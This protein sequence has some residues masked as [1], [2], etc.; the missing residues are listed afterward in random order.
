MC[1]KS[2]QLE[3]MQK[4][5]ITKKKKNAR[6]LSFFMEFYG[7]ELVNSTSSHPI[8][9]SEVMEA[10]PFEVDPNCIHRYDKSAKMETARIIE[11]FL[12]AHSKE[13]LG[14]RQVYPKVIQRSAKLNM[15]LVKWK[16]Y[17]RGDGNEELLWN[18]DKAKTQKTKISVLSSV[19]VSECHRV[20]T[21]TSAPVQDH[22]VE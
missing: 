6:P 16:I 17:K 7:E 18:L 22:S 5:E 2:I 8:L 3:I 12:R 4:W 1:K 13:V 14:A 11:Y 9:L 19:N 10:N 20:Y 21:V 15:I